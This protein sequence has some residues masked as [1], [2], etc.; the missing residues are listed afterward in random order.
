MNPRPSTHHLAFEAFRLLQHSHYTAYAHAHLDPRE[1]ERAVRD[2]FTTVL[3]AWREIITDPAPA[4]RAW[5]HLRTEVHRHHDAP[6]T[7]RDDIRTLAAL[8]Y[9]AQDTAAL[10]GLSPG[11]VRFL[12]RHTTHHHP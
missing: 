9:S 3:G 1:A 4:Q 5:E 12:A 2:T 8:G 11:K 6:A 10:T 7:D